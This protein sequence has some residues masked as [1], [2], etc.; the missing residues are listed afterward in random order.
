[1]RGQATAS[2]HTGCRADDARHERREHAESSGKPP[3]DR[4]A[5]RRANE[6][7]QL[8]HVIASVSISLAPLGLQVHERGSG[9]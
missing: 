1:M 8:T 6:C 7:E 4:T 3:A 2:I 5:D 9:L